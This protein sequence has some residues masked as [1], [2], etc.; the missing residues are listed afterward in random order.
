MGIGDVEDVDIVADAGTVGRRVIGAEDF[1]V[2]NDAESSVEN[3]RDEVGLDAMGLAALGGGTGGVEIAESGE[4]ETG[5][6]AIVGKDFLEAELGFAVGINGIFGMVFGDGD[7]VRLAVSGGGGRK[8]EL[9]YAVAGHGVK[10]I[11][12]AGDVGGVEGAGFAD[13][14]GDEGFACKMHDRVDLVL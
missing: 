14:L 7:G 12:A 11:D 10:E 6:G 13:G 8:N 9:F 2:R 5:V 1:E 3:F 4:K